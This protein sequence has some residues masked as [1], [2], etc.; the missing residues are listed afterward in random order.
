MWG[1]GVAVSVYIFFIQQMPLKWLL[2]FRF[3]RN[4]FLFLSSLSKLAGGSR[5]PFLFPP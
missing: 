2:P 3:L 1:G 4:P 5:S